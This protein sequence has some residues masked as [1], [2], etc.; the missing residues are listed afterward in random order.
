MI[1]VIV[2]YL[3]VFIIHHLIYSI[4]IRVSFYVTYLHHLYTPIIIIIINTIH[5]T[6]ITIII[7]LSI[8][9][10]IIHPPITHPISPRLLIITHHLI[11]YLSKYSFSSYP[12]VSPYPHL[13]HL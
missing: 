7:N 10:I 12:I 2:N 6:S 8:H 5:P 4:I 11:L 13:Y 3:V 9:P 1:M